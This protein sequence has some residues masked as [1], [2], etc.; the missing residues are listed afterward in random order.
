MS[1]S[2]PG[3]FNLTLDGRPLSSEYDQE[4]DILYLWVGRE[5]QEAISVTSNEGHLVRLDPETYDVVGL[6]VFE[7]SEVLNQPGTEFVVSLP[8]LGEEGEITEPTSFA[9]VGT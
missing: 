9:L 5:P 7:A 3:S 8:S 6:T 1:V 2:A 4:A